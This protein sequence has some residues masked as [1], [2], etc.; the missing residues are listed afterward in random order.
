MMHGQKNIKKAL[1][2]FRAVFRPSSEAYRT[3]C[4]AFHTSGKQQESMTIPKAAH[5]IL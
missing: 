4:S 3:I 2:M 5:K 1:Y